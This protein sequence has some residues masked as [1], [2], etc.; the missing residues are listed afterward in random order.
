MATNITEIRGTGQG[1]TADNRAARVTNLET[2]IGQMQPEQAR[3]VLSTLQGKIGN[4]WGYLRL[5]GS[6]SGQEVGFTTRWNTNPFR[7]ARGEATGAALKA[8]FEKAGYDTTALSAYLEQRGNAGIKLDQV[9]RF[10]PANQVQVQGQRPLDAQNQSINRHALV[11]TLRNGC[12]SII[13]DRGTINWSLSEIQNASTSIQYQPESNRHKYYYGQD[14]NLKFADQVFYLVEESF[15][16]DWS[17]AHFGIFNNLEKLVNSARNDPDF[18]GVVKRFDDFKATHSNAFHAQQL[19]AN[20][21]DAADRLAE[22]EPAGIEASENFLRLLNQSVGDDLKHFLRPSPLALYADEAMQAIDAVL[23]RPSSPEIQETAQ[24]LK[25]KLLQEFAQP[26]LEKS[27][28]RVVDALPE[29]RLAQVEWMRGALETLRQEPED[30]HGI[31]IPFSNFSEGVNLFLHTATELEKKQPLSQEF[32]ASVGNIREKHEGDNHVKQAISFIR[33]SVAYDK[34]FKVYVFPLNNNR[35]LTCSALEF[36]AW[37]TGKNPEKNELNVWDWKNGK[38]NN[39]S[40]GAET[41]R[42]EGLA[43][44]PLFAKGLATLDTAIARS[45]VDQVILQGSD[46][47]ATR[48]LFLYGLSG[49]KQQL[50]SSQQKKEIEPVFT[51][52]WGND[53]N[54]LDTSQWDNL[55]LDE[56]HFAQMKNLMPPE[57]GQDDEAYSQF[58]F[59]LSA[60]FT[61]LGSASVWG[62]EYYSVDELRL[63]GYLLQKQARQVNPNLLAESDW[64]KLAV[65]YKDSSKC[66]QILSGDQLRQAKTLDQRAYQLIVPMALQ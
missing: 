40:D 31:S 17:S 32:Q 33:D 64:N 47:D 45:V 41:A 43:K 28:I 48:N 37:V 1:S 30:I 60:V 18:Q 24:N 38:V 54:V 36:E 9:R 2:Q 35:I 13:G 49:R 46:D 11:N 19:K 5:D 50:S 25:N 16:S 3:Q 66:A 57:L 51:R 62:S 26:V 15:P 10:L 44:V 12:A 58:L 34:T 65:G 14:Q 20:I 63:Y 29:I 27:K 61:K 6:G 4:R 39:P 22:S 42:L 21:H 8:L 56:N 59:N 52:I 55:R 7:S 23:A 53:V